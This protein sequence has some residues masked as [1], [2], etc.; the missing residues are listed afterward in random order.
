MYEIHET[1]RSEN[2]QRL[3]LPHSDGWG[4]ISTTWSDYT[5]PGACSGSISIFVSRRLAKTVCLGC[6]LART[7]SLQGNTE[8]SCCRYLCHPKTLPSD[9][10]YNKKPPGPAAPQQVMKILDD[11]LGNAHNLPCIFLCCL[12]FSF[13]PAKNQ[14]RTSAVQATIRVS[15]IRLP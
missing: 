7:D 2:P 3:T 12:F 6:R 5:Y 4:P 11:V 10:S 15:R 8:A 14:I 13:W 9:R 1:L